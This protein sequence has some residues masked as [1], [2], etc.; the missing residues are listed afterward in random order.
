MPSTAT[1]STPLCLI[2]VA[3]VAPAGSPSSTLSRLPHLT[4]SVRPSQTRFPDKGGTTTTTARLV[5]SAHGK[6]AASAAT[7][8]SLNGRTKPLP[9]SD[10]SLF[11]PSRQRVVDY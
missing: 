1:S 10:P 6:R 2:R 3:L 7:P 11:V 9:A 5:T 4:N 8:F